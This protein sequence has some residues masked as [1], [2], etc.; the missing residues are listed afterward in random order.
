MTVCSGIQSH[1]LKVHK[2]KL[3]QGNYTA[4]SGLVIEVTEKGQTSISLS[5]SVTGSSVVSSEVAWIGLSGPEDSGSRGNILSTR[6]TIPDL[7]QESVY[8]ISVTVDTV[9][10]GIL[11]DFVITFT[12]NSTGPIAI[13]YCFQQLLS[14]S[15]ERVAHQQ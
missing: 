11:T 12:G 14:Q 7:Q 4:L 5:W 8:N 9:Y 3:Y 2:F 6:Y 13:V 15:V 1:S 10:S